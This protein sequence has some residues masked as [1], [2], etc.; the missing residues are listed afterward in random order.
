M[1]PVVIV[2]LGRIGA[3]NVELAGATPLSHLAAVRAVEGF[4]VTGLVDPDPTM[5]GVA[6]ADIVKGPAPVSDLSELPQGTGE[7]IAI[8]T[9]VDSHPQVLEKALARKPRVVIVEKPLAHS[10]NDARRMVTQAE[11]AGAVLRVNF[12]RRFDGRFVR[13]RV[14]TTAPSAVVARYG[15]GLM[16]YGS[17][18]ID[19][20]LDW[21]G[22]VDSVQAL[23]VSADRSVDASQGFRC[24][25]AAGFDVTAIGIDGL[26]YD[27]LEIDVMRRDDRVELRAGGA[28]IRRYVPSE[29]LYYKGY[30]HLTEVEADRDTAPVGGFVELYAAIARHLNSGALLSGCDGQAALEG[31]AVLEAVR[32]SAASGG[33]AVAPDA[34]ARAA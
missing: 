17:H 4:A 16:N 3:G 32:R 25:M 29:G 8:C 21:Y 28:D 20:M 31:M 12:N 10:F 30:R 13:W 23:G 14:K 11:K 7:V 2:G 33:L 34:L 26:S 1:I 5:R 19:L 15:K 9:P 6:G 24:R 18:L 27:Q 22:R